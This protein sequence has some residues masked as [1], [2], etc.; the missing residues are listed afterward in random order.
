[1]T[2]Q[3][4]PDTIDGL[5]ERV[6]L[7]VELRETFEAFVNQHEDHADVLERLRA[8]P[9][10]EILA[11]APSGLRNAMDSAHVAKANAILTNDES[12]YEITRA[13][14]NARYQLAQ[15]KAGHPVAEGIGKALC[16]IGLW[17][18]IV[19]AV[20][21]AIAVTQG[22]AIAPLIA[23]DAGLVSVLAAITGLS[24][25]WITATAAAGG[26]T[27]GILIREACASK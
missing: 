5:T 17:A 25:N 14:N 24:A 11:H 19:A 7:L 27:F 15:A 20:G 18:A 12:Q 10:A 4:F 21:A 1:M 9:M 23:V 13:L 2:T 6:D 8:D 26:L 3:T 16:E 22:A